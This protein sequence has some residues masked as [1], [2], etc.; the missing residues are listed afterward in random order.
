MVQNKNRPFEL[1]D[2]N[3][4]NSMVGG[5]RSISDISNRP[6]ARRPFSVDPLERVTLER[7]FLC[8]KQNYREKS[9][10]C[11]SFK[12]SLG[13]DDIRQDMSTCVLRDSQ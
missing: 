13:T 4:S 6:K 2:L 12:L 1:V 10:Q 11:Q 8:K 9:Q 7:Y 5:N 3:R